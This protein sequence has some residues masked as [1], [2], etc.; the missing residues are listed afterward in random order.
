MSGPTLREIKKEFKRLASPAQAKKLSR[1]FK[2]GPGEYAEGDHFLG[3]KVP[4]QRTLVKKYRDLPLVDVTAL[5][6][7]TIH[8]HRFTALL[9]LVDQFKR[10]G[11]DPKVRSILRK[12]IYNLYLKQT[13]YVNNWDLVDSSAPYIVGEYLRVY[14]VDRKILYKLV[15]SKNLWERRIAIIATQNFIRHGE[16][17]DTVRL[18]RLLLTDTHDLIHKAIGWMLR[19]VGDRDTAVLEKFLR[20]NVS[21]LPRTALRY[22]LEH[23]PEKKRARYMAVVPFRTQK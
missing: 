21:R 20:Q 19:E 16:S 14:G 10:G 1:F 11:T 7:S 9:I 23:F 18:A 3:I 2:T 17:D 12:N 13:K 8:E 6:Q 4:V 22:A 5:L 15:R